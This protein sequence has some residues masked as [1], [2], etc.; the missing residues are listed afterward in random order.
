MHKF[1]NYR[2]KNKLKYEI[3]E[4]KMVVALCYFVVFGGAWFVYAHHPIQYRYFQNQC[5]GHS[6]DAHSNRL[7]FAHDTW[8]FFFYAGM[9]RFKNLISTMLQ[10]IVSNLAVRYK[11]KI[12]LDDTLDVFPCHGV[13]GIM[14][15]LMTGIFAKDVGLIY[16]Q[17]NTFLYHLLALLLVGIFTFGGSYLLYMLT[18]KIIPMRVVSEKEELG[19]DLSQHNEVAA[20]IETTNAKYSNKL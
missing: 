9:V 4:Q 12:G 5:G 6:L 1:A 3:Y 2:F 17:S 15:M 14:G 10:S 18:D 16:G 8:T 11:N 19:L 7:G 20:S 13:G